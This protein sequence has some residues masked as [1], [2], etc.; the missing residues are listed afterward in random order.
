MFSKK[1]QKT[2]LIVL[3]A[4]VTISMLMTIVLPLYYF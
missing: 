3:T 2:L 1:K 4:L